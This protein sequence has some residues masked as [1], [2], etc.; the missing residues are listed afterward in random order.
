M[1]ERANEGV[2]SGAEEGVVTGLRSVGASSR[3]QVMAS[4]A[5]TK[6]E[7]YLALRQLGEKAKHHT[8][9]RSHK[10][11]I[12]ASCSCSWS[13]TETFKDTAP[14]RAYAWKVASEK[15]EQHWRSIKI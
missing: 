8:N 11:Y 12:V 2:R 6:P 5:T 9:V 15:A 10:T 1:D 3:D 4:L 13:H 7:C 14:Q